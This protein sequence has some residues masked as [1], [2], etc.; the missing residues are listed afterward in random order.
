MNRIVRIAPGLLVGLIFLVTAGNDH[1]ANAAESA[2]ISVTINAD[3]SGTMIANSRTNPDSETWS[4]EACEPDLSSCARFG[5]G[6]IVST[7]GAPAG[8]VFW[9]NSSLG[10]SASSPLWRGRVSSSGPPSI[11]G[12]IQANELVAPVAGRWRGGWAGSV[13]WTQLAACESRSG[14]HCT[15]LTDMH[16]P[17][18]CPRG[19]A[20]LDPQFASQY[21][22]VADMRVGPHAL[23][24]EYAVGSPYGQKLWKRSQIVAVAILSR[25]LP[26]KGPRTTSC[27]PPPLGQEPG[28]RT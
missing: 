18:A 7:R 19:A 27:G 22:R 13:D 17:Y 1:K 25:I 14:R 23:I 24:L 5:S 21:L 11:H 4:W 28:R 26:A 16:Y 9:A 8:S 2:T 10:A 15:T 12:Q 3:G 6:R 20:V